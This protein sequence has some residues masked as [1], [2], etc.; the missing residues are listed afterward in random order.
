MKARKKTKMKRVVIFFLW[1]T[2]AIFF[3]ALHITTVHANKSVLK[4]AHENSD[5]N[6]LKAVRRIQT[7]FH[8]LRNKK[9]YTKTSDSQNL[10]ASPK[11]SSIKVDWIQHLSLSSAILND[12]DLTHNTYGILYNTPINTFSSCVAGLLQ[13]F[14]TKENE[15]VMNTFFLSLPLTSNNFRLNPY[16]IHGEVSKDLF[17]REN[18]ENS[19]WR[20]EFFPSFAAINHSILD[21]DSHSIYWIGSSYGL[22]AFEPLS[23]AGNIIY[24]QIDNSSWENKAKAWY[25][26]FTATYKMDQVSPELFALYSFGNDMELLEDNNYYST[27][28]SNGWVMTPMYLSYRDPNAFSLGRPNYTF[29][30]PDPQGI[31][32]AGLALK[33]INVVDKMT[34]A[35][36]ISYTQG[37]Y[38]KEKLDN[39]LSLCPQPTYDYLFLSDEDSMLRAQ[40]NSRYSI[41]E[42][43]AAIMELGYTKLNLEKDN[44]SKNY[45]PDENAYSLSFGLTYDF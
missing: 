7:Y 6:D 25:F 21:N 10:Y 14:E 43:L 17:S 22:T 16:F 35:F 9:L 26:D 18:S 20:Y 13:G 23:I 42:N 33:D 1:I 36:A 2:I 19:V 38:D 28:L 40:L 3:I 27:L 8:Y 11:L 5:Y 32:K 45:S 37:L 30:H 31:W 24:G 39:R 15:N 44:Y 34:N 4:Q 41:Y 12:N 29:F